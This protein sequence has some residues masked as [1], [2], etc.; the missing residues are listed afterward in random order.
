[1]AL[2]SNSLAP[3]VGAAVEN[4]QFLPGAQNLPRKI[5]VIGNYDEATFTTVVE[6]VPQRVLSPEDVGARMG[7]GFMLHRLVKK[8][9]AGSQG[10]ECWVIPQ[11]ENVAAVV[12]DGKIT[13]TG[14]ATAA[15]NLVVYVAGERVNVPVAKGDV[16]NV[17]A[18]LL[19][20]AVTADKELPI[21]AVVDGVIDTQVNTTAKTKGVWGNDIDLAI[22]L[23]FEEELPPGIS[24]VIVGMANGTTLGDIQDALDGM[25]TGDDANREHFTEVVHGYGQD[26]TTLDALSTYNGIGN[27]F[28]GLYSKTISRPFRSLV[29]DVEDTGTPLT[30]LISLADGRKLDRTNGVLGVPGVPNHPAEL[31]ALTLGI[32]A[33]IN[34][35][36]AAESYIG[37]V[38]P[39]V[40]PSA[41]SQWNSDYDNR[42][43]AVKAGV[44]PT[45]V[46]GN[47][48]KLSSVL[49]FYHPDSVPIT[50]NGYR[51]QRN[52]SILQNILWNIRR[53][54]EQ[55]KWQGI[56]IVAD[57][58]KV[59]NSVDRK[60][61]R[62]ISAVIDDLLALT[63][64]FEGKAW[65]FS[66]DFTIKKLQAG[67]LVTIR[68]GGT[69]FNSV[70]PVLL[71][72]EAGILDNVV[73]FDTALDIVLST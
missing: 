52:I 40:I 32:M 68:P 4:V 26:T 21:S 10:V 71:S 35:E 8:V 56:T 9:F 29:G 30:D 23:G 55:E 53:N 65:I 60:K 46:E 13:I 59:S 15:G 69:G 11:P 43:L 41:V 54:F 45:T 1:M 19:V 3:V 61:T 28:V 62:D 6:D 31:A 72:G 49:T 48:V 44:S 67:G 73:E 50:S 51:S 17:I 38:L 7:F 57:V 58:T 37:Q 47:L 25:G 27:D 22:N 5:V 64:A 14:T 18:P 2:Q 33:R 20:A 39:G 12:A 36:R 34:N 24:V 63:R 70:L 16:G 42:D 66:A